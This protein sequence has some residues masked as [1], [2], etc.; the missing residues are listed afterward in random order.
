M[1]NELPQHEE[2]LRYWF[3]DEIPGLKLHYLAQCDPF[4][5]ALR[6]W[7]GRNIPVSSPRLHLDHNRLTLLE[8]LDAAL[9]MRG[10]VCREGFAT[11]LDKTLRL[12]PS[13]YGSRYK[14]RLDSAV[15]HTTTLFGWNDSGICNVDSYWGWDWICAAQGN[16]V[17]FSWV[18]SR[19]YQQ[20][21]R[22]GATQPR[23]LILTQRDEIE[24][25]TWM[26]DE[27]PEPQAF[28]ENLV[29]SGAKPGLEKFLGHPENTHVYLL[30]ALRNAI[31]LSRFEPQSP[32]VI[33]FN[34]LHELVVTLLTP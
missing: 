23:P 17:S 1:M 28:G 31:G 16:P 34:L 4:I 26:F 24:D 33:E 7:I 14:F 11:V 32:S 5:F 25:Y 18:V 8:L 9:S 12:F 27:I 20:I 3:Y 30:R 21:G 22:S 15:T 10:G 2:G 29:F 6:D 19:P 13:V